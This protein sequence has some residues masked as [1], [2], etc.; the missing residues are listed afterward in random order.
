MNYTELLDNLRMMEQD[1]REW[2]VE[3][4]VNETVTFKTDWYK[5]LE[6]NKHGYFSLYD[7]SDNSSMQDKEI[8]D[9]L[10]SDYRK[11]FK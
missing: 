10:S 8:V 11:W 3:T 1:G 5:V 9:F 7:L 2:T 4:D 6:F